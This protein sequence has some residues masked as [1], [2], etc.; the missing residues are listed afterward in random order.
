MNTNSTTNG[1]QPSSGATP[2]KNHLSFPAVDG[3]Q[4]SLN[5]P[6]TT[7]RPIVILGPTT[8]G[9]TEVAFGLARRLNATVINAD[10]FYLYD[11]LPEVTGQSDADQ[12]PDIT[13]QLYGRLQPD[14]ALWSPNRYRSELRSCLAEAAERNQ[15]IIV[16]GCSNALV[17]VAIETLSSTATSEA[18]QPLII[19]LQWRHLTQLPADCA[20]RASRMFAAGMPRSFDQACRE[21]MQ[22]TYLLRKCFAREPLLALQ[23][24]SHSRMACQ[25][26][27]AE[28]LERHAHR[29]HERMSRIPKVAWLAHDRRQVAAT[30]N[31]ILTLHG[32]PTH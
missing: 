26:R 2:C 13:S 24:R 9:K 22:E 4:Q 28:L 23:R 16:E 32:Q 11:A 20:G 25:Q 15:Q 14:E 1:S 21:R 30:V 27:V 10:K 29:H 7:K 8:V 31:R 18:E 5:T 17:R 12:Y 3:M 19:G 6:L